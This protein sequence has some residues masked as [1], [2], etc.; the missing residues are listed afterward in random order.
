[1]PTGLY[2]TLVYLGNY[3]LAAYHARHQ[4]VLYYTLI[5]V[6]VQHVLFDSCGLALENDT[7]S[8]PKNAIGSSVCFYSAPV[9]VRSIANSSSVCV[10]LSVREHTSRTAGPI[11]TKLC[12]DTLWPWLG[13]PLA[14]LRYAMYFWFYA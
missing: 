6:R 7:R 2:L 1:M 12:A 4:T 13:P 8:I 3:V 9:G 10:C 14:A 11:F 5:T